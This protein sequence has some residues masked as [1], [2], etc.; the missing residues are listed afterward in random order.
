MKLL[1]LSLLLFI[2]AATAAKDYTTNVS[3]HKAKKDRINSK[4]NP[5]KFDYL[6]LG[7]VKENPLR[8][9]NYSDSYLVGQYKVQASNLKGRSKKLLFSGPSSIPLR[10]G[11]IRMAVKDE[12][13]NMK[14]V[15][16]GCSGKKVGGKKA[17]IPCVIEISG[18]RISTGNEAYKQVKY[19]NTNKM[20]KVNLED[21]FWSLQL[22]S[23]RVTAAGKDGE[24]ND[25]VTL[26]LDSF[27]YSVG[28]E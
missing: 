24:V 5:I 1:F 25:D 8:Q 13:F 12:V 4:P 18:R 21:D 6:S 10:S 7:P 3:Y 20:L 16:V 15:E 11:L 9:L 26:L 27:N 2:T 23:F 17:T 14:T 19:T 22:L 28:K